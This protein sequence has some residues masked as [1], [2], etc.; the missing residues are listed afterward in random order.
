MTVTWLFCY[1]EHSE[2]S[3]PQR[4]GEEDT[5]DGFTGFLIVLL[6]FVVRFVLPILVMVLV[7]Y[8]LN[9]LYAYW[10]KQ[11]HILPRT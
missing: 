9:Q 1:A 4:L 7:G 6:L 11:D 10:D 3:F 2:I 8:L 5:M